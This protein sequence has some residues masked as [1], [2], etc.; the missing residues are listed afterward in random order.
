MA[1]EQNFLRIFYVFLGLSSATVLPVQ[2]V[3]TDVLNV[4]PAEFEIIFK[5]AASLWMVK[6]VIGFACNRFVNRVESYK[7]LLTVM[8]TLNSIAWLFLSSWSPIDLTHNKSAIIGLLWVVFSSLCVCDVATDGRMVKYVQLEN[9]N[10]VGR[11]QTYTW[12]ARSVGHLIGGI[13]VTILIERHGTLKGKVSP[14]QFI[15]GFVILPILF[16]MILWG[17]I[18]P[19]RRTHEMDVP[20]ISTFCDTLSTVFSSVR[21]NHKIILFLIVLF[22]TPSTGS[23]MYLYLSESIEHHGLGFGTDILGIIG[24]VHSIACI[25]GALV[26]QN[27][28][29]RRNT[30]HLF[31]GAILFGTLLSLSQLILLTGIYK[32]IGLSPKVFV[33]SDDVVSSILDEFLMLPL[34]IVL[35]NQIPSGY[36]TVGYA[37]FTSIE[38]IV[39]ALSTLISAGMTEAL[40]IVRNSKDNSINFDQLWIMVIICA[41]SSLIPLALIGWVPKQISTYRNI[42]GDEIEESEIELTGKP[43]HEIGAPDSDDEYASSV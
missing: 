29:T 6:F 9:A 43:I 31:I 23:N 20:S 40:G 11:T 4:Q 7:W 12:A 17:G 34:M 38:N 15:D 3:L 18:E 22:L 21:K 28:C 27:C 1:R 42:P 8:L 39:S 35:A 32:D 19:A 5:I 13:A 36:E 10:E 30:R 37:L 25:I 33:I 16:I 41:A 14:Q 2:F 24:I 26:Y